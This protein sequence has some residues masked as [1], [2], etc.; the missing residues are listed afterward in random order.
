MGEFLMS[1]PGESAGPGGRTRPARRLFLGS[2]AAVVGGLVAACAPAP[3]APPTPPTISRFAI[4]AERTEAPVLGVLGW[5]LSDPNPDVL[6]CRVDLDG[7]GTFDREIVPCRSADTVLSEFVTPGI[8]TLTLEVDDGVF[9]PVTRTRSINVLPGP[10]E[11]YEITLRLGAGMR[12]EFQEAF[13]AAAARWSEAI[14]AGVPDQYLDLS[15]NV[16]GFPPFAGMVDDVLIDAR[17]VT[18]D[19]PGGVLGRAGGFAI[20]EDNWQPYYG[21]MEFD[22]DDLDRL[23]RTGRLRDVILHEMGHVL[24]IGASWLLTGDVTDF[25]LDPKYTG[26]AGVAAYQ[27][28][29]G[30]RFVPLETE[31]SVGTVIGHWREAVF[32]NELMTGYLNSGLQPLS[33]MTIAALADQGYG[34]SLAAADPYALPNPLD[35]LRAPLL[36][37]HTDEIEPGI[38]APAG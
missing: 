3:E 36:D 13:E 10:S 4:T 18:I 37:L 14:V 38:I 9:P 20:R 23:A 17:D 6:R 35:T 32:G 7:D 11:S 15:F 34:V 33:R 12:T 8:R 25:P 28:L 21:I 30:N 27:E 1:A 24:G 29:G 5:T 26:A 2:V 22:T 31:G 16:F 19:G